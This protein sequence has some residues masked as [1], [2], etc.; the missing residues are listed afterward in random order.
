MPKISEAKD[1][2]HV[3]V[4]ELEKAKLIPVT[5]KIIV[6]DSGLKDE[7]LMNPRALFFLVIWYFFS[8]CTLFLNKYILTELRGD[9]LLLGAMQMVMTTSLGFLQMFLPLGFYT[10]IKRD[11]KPP[12]F[13]R[14]MVIVGSMR[15][16]DVVLGL[17]AL[18]FVA[19]SFTETVKSSAPIFTVFISYIMLGEYSGVFTV[20]SLIPIMF[21]LGLCTMYELSFNVEG[22]A[23][24]LG[25]NILEC[26]QNVYSKMLIS[27]EK[28][29]YTPAELQFF[30]SI[31]SVIVQ[32][33]ACIIMIDVQHAKKTMDVTMFTIFILNGVFF[34]FQ[35]ISAY[36]LMG[37]IS[38]V[39]HSVANTVKRAFLIWLSV[40]VFSNPV[41]FFSGLGTA[42]VTVGVLCYTKA[43]QIDAA[44][45]ALKYAVDE[46]IIVHKQL[47]VKT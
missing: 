38:P 26:L 19:V 17:V 29:R 45:Q 25:T 3:G 40:I 36:V 41:T 14:N 35:S 10:N 46:E 9:P 18:K 47:R 11:G 39:T 31:S 13:W 12:N 27:G 15:F 24:S 44:K 42:I 20:L 6:K 7:G 4:M 1:F 21:G 16:S 5:D 34:H 2:T 22:F 37:Y 43:K 33:P 8:F 32:I 28:Y 30:T 23:A